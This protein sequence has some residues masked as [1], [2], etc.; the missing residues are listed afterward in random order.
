PHHIRP[1]TGQKKQ[2]QQG[3][4]A[5]HEMS[6]RLNF[7]QLICEKISVKKAAPFSFCW[8]CLYSDADK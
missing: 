2:R 1:I 3:L 6:S 8:W 5:L 4:P 7:Q